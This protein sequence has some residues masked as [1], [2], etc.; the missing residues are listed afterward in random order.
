MI[1]SDKELIDSIEKV[2]SDLP[3]KMREEREKAIEI[4]KKGL[5][6]YNKDLLK[7]CSIFESKP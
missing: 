6:D 1:V 2:V 7:I 3:G 5:A 4:Q